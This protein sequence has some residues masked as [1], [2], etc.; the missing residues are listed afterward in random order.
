MGKERFLKAERSQE[1]KEIISKEYIVLGT[2]ASLRGTE[3]V[4]QQITRNSRL[5]G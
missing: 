1:K 2:V 3:M 4:C 5:A